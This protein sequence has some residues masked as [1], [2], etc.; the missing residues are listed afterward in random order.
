MTH[1]FGTCFIFPR[2]RLLTKLER[3]PVPYFLRISISLFSVC[4][5]QRAVPLLALLY[6]DLGTAHVRGTD[7]SAHFRP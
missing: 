1:P 7:S 6:T 3:L 5:Q 2:S 4:I